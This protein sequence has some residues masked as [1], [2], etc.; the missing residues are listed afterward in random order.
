MIPKA[1]MKNYIKENITTIKPT[2]SYSGETA[3]NPAYESISHTPTFLAEGEIRIWALREDLILA[4]GIKNA[5]QAEFGYQGLKAAFPDCLHRYINWDYRYG[6]PSLTVSENSFV[7]VYLA[8][9]VKRDFGVIKVFLASGRY[10]RED[11]STKDSIILENYV[12]NLFTIAYGDKTV[13][14]YHGVKAY[15][16]YES[17]ESYYRHIG[18]F[19]DRSDPLTEEPYRC[20]KRSR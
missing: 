4:T 9:Y 8:G 1:V 17:D 10:F 11:L 18:R 16:C 19:F 12:A 2:Y 13:K 15:R 7:G 14:V 5:Y 6:H 20:Y 3:I